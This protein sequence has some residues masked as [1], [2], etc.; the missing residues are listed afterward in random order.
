MSQLTYATAVR[1][2][3]EQRLERGRTEVERV[4]A[5]L[6]KAVDLEAVLRGLDSDGEL[7]PSDGA[8]PPPPS[9]PAPSPT[10]SAPPSRNRPASKQDKQRQVD[11][12]VDVARKL[13]GRQGLGAITRAA[14]ALSTYQA[15]SAVGEAVRLGRLEA[16]GKGAGTRY[17]ATESKAPV[18]EGPPAGRGAKAGENQGPTVQGRILSALQMGEATAGGLGISLG[19]PLGEITPALGHLV[20]DGDVSVA[21]GGK[22]R[23]AA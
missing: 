3:L 7:K 9:V 16:V 11:V 10:P 21:K 1:E 13:G 6:V 20:H 8:G 2:Y 22:Y 4:E 18:T 15:K 23:L 5:A 19:L 14:T 12:V 17:V